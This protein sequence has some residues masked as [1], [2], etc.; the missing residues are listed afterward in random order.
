MKVILN[1]IMPKSRHKGHASKKK[2]RKAEGRKSGY[3]SPE[4]PEFQRFAVQLAGQGLAL[5]DVAGDG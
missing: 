5:L 1:F 2:G 4:D 3:V